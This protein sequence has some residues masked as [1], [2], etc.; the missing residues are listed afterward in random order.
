M[1]FLLPLLGGFLFYSCSNQGSHALSF[2]V[3][4]RDTLYTCDFAAV[5]DEEKQIKLSDLIES[6]QIVRFEN[7]D[8]ALFKTR[9]VYISANYIGIL[10]GGGSPFKLFNHEGN[11]LCDVGGIGQAEGEYT[12]LYSAAI[13]EKDAS[14]WLAPFVGTHLWKYNMEGKCVSTVK[15]LPMNKPSMRFEKDSSL[16]MT[17]LYFTN[18]SGFLYLRLLK[19]DSIYYSV[20]EKEHSYSPYNAEGNFTGCNQEIWFYNNS[21]RFTYMTTYSDTLYTYDLKEDRT[22]PRFVTTFQRDQKHFLVYNELPS[23]FLINVIG[24]GDDNDSKLI[25]ADKMSGEASCV[26]IYNDFMGN[27]PVSSFNP[28]NGWYHRMYEPIELIELLEKQLSNKE[29]SKQDRAKL[30]ELLSSIDENDN[31]IMFMGKLAK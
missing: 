28:S 18:R 23:S 8:S 20:A 5:P 10:Q 19:N 7:V 6:F 31:N 11:F 24:F 26:K 21:E 22:K 2:Q 13:N 1:S 17:D 3:T 4:E 12:S 30:K 16:T 27:L 9:K 15:T 29:C 25:I 14:I